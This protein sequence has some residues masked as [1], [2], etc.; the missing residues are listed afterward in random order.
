LPTYS[1]IE[2]QII[3]GNHND[4][5]PPSATSWPRSGPSSAPRTQGASISTRR[6]RSSLERTC[7][8]ASTTRL[9]G[10]PLQHPGS[11]PA[12]SATAA[13]DLPCGGRRHRTIR[14]RDQLADHQP[15]AAEASSRWLAPPPVRRTRS[16][17]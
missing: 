16:C 17:R 9:L 13:A 8:R 4:M 3:G 2:P 7:W 5:H 11:S 1:F 14:V 15:L 6:P 10:G 12:R